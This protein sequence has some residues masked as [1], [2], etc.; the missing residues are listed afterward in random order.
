MPCP[1]GEEEAIEGE[2]LREAREGRPLVKLR[3]GVD[4]LDALPPAGGDG[5]QIGSIKLERA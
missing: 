5:L 2:V 1:T 3:D 4:A